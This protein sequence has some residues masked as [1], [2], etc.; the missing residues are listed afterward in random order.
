MVFDDQ[1][2]N[3][4]DGDFQEYDST[5]FYGQVIEDVPSNAPEPRGMLIQINAFIDANHAQ[6]KVTRCSHTGVLIYLNKAP[7]IWF[8]KAQE[9]VETS[10]FG[11]EFIALNTANKNTQ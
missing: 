11:S 2:I 1:Y 10:T 4:N 5:D 9:T 3:W 6:N 8:S 7:I